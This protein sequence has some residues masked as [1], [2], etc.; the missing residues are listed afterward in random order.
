MFYSSPYT[1]LGQ[2]IDIRKTASRIDLIADGIIIAS[3][4]RMYGRKGQ[5]STDSTHMP[6]TWGIIDNPWSKERF[7]KW[8][9]SIGPATKEA[10]LRVLASRAIVEQAFVPCQNILGLAKKYGR[11]QVEQACSQLV[12]SPHSMPTYTAVK[13]LC[14]EHRKRLAEQ[15][16]IHNVEV[17]ASDKLKSGGRTRGAEHYR[18][19]KRDGE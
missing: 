16:S 4:G 2:R 1:Y 19:G 8:A 18:L 5:Y 6:S 10:V 11:K 12:C 7:I 3:H 15:G 13:E 17:P 14:I 9:E